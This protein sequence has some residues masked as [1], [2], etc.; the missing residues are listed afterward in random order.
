[1]ERNKSGRHT[2]FLNYKAE[3]LSKIFFYCPKYLPSVGVIFASR[4]SVALVIFFG[5]ESHIEKVLLPHHLLLLTSHKN[6]LSL[7]KFSEKESTIESLDPT[8][9]VGSQG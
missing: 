9:S 8:S 4:P 1:M 5:V 7:T 2:L 3:N 6:I